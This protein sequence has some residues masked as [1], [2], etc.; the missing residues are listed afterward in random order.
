MPI[1]CFLLP[2]KSSIPSYVAGRRWLF[3]LLSCPFASSSPFGLPQRARTQPRDVRQ[4]MGTLP[5]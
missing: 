1:E 2:P 5:H 3:E 4:T